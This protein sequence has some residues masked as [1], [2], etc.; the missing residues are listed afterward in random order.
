MTERE[1]NKISNFYNALKRLNEANVV[2]KKSKNDDIC[3]DALIKRFEFTFELAWKSLK[4]F[5]TFNGVT[6]RDTPRDV[7]KTAYQGGFIN[8][9]KVWLAMMEARNLTAHI[10]KEAQAVAIA[11][12]ISVKYCKEL[13]SLKTL[14]GEL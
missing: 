3:R 4:E 8:N 11:D 5:L 9:E 12:D 1:E 2:Y 6:V 7:L 10:Y 13:S 14:F